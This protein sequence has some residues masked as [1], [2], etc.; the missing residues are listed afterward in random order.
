MTLGIA[1]RLRSAARRFRH[2]SPPW[3]VIL[4]YHRVDDGEPDAWG[5]TVTPERFAEQMDVLRRAAQ[6]LSIDRLLATLDHARPSVPRVA[7]TFDDG[8]AE[9]LRAARVVLE[10]HDIPA[11]AFLTSGYIGS[12]RE[13]WWDALARALFEPRKLPEKLT[14][15]IGGVAC[16]WASSS[17]G[18]GRYGH[19]RM[20]ASLYRRMRPLPDSDRR[21]LLDELRGWAGVAA[22][23]RAS[24]RPPSEDDVRQFAAGGLIEIGAH[25]ETHPTLGW[26]P[27]FRQ[28]EEIEG[29]KKRLEGIVGRPVTQFAY[30]HGHQ[31]DYTRES[32]TLVREAGFSA[33]CAA[34]SGGVWPDADRFAL[35]RIQAQNWDGETFAR[36]L[37]RLA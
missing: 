1:R 32:E 31:S 9:T 12:E 13:F 16:E 36:L 19:R 34:F 29:S 5:L 18:R 25:T 11:T 17:Q 3:A 2:G 6:P 28:R 10:Q 23:P 14:L 22:I 33:A 24:H 20:F 37:R 8:Y 27:A 15:R 30:P 21:L 26:L 4:L 35:P 7:V